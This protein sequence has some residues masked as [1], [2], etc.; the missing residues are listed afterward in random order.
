MVVDT[1]RGSGILHNLEGFIKVVNILLSDNENA[2]QFIRVK[3]RTACASSPPLSLTQIHRHT[4][5][6]ALCAYS[7][8]VYSQ[9]HLV[10]L[11]P[12]KP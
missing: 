9:P 7:H 1:V 2:P 10:L 8:A 6:Q 11:S 4:D 3:G 12:H 5:T